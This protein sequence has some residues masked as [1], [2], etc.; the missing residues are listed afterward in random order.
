VTASQTLSAVDLY[1]QGM[2]RRVAGDYDKAIDCHLAALKLDPE[3]AV[4]QYDLALLW[5]LQGDLDKA[6]AAAQEATRLKPDLAAAHLELATVRRSQRRI[7]EAQASYLETLRLD[8]SIR[9]AALGL[10]TIADLPVMFRAINRFKDTFGLVV[11]GGVFRGLKFAED[12]CHWEFLL[13]RLIG[14]Y[15][16]ELWHIVKAVIKR[17]FKT[18]IDIGACDGYYVVGFAKALPKSHVYS[19]DTWPLTH[20]WCRATAELN[21]TPNVD[22]GGGC[23]HAT[24][25]KLCGPDTFLLL[26][27]EGGERGILDPDRC[28]ELRQ[29]TILTEVHDHYVVGTTDALLKRFGR[30]HSITHYRPGLHVPGDYPCLANFPEDEQRIAMGERNEYV[31][32]LFMQPI[33]AKII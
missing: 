9:D 3:L 19:F 26:D 8:P 16:R 11:Q 7:D 22:V 30:T 17:E 15:E 28:P 29:T 32:W 33:G 31:H 23:D 18:I 4:A 21:G 13:P 5:R 1:M 20:P 2:T 25:S 6:A 10:Y 24:L 27:C 14:S 12:A